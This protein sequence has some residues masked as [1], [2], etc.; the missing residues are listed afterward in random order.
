VVLS[1]TVLAYGGANFVRSDQVRTVTKQVTVTKT[2][3]PRPT[4][5]KTRTVE[6][7]RTVVVKVTPKQAA[8]KR[9]LSRVLVVRKP[10]QSG[11]DVAA[12]G[13]LVGAPGS[14]YDARMASKVKA[15][16]KRKHLAVDG[17]FGCAS[18]RAAGW[19]CR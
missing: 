14:R 3:A 19:S 8:P 4:V 9:T 15:W 1:A 13:K 18:A 2:V 6:K 5:T 11:N 16:Q 17:K 10:V 7:T 12:I